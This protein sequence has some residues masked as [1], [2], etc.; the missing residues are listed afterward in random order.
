[1]SGERYDNAS[2][3]EA[4]RYAANLTALAELM[5]GKTRQARYAALAEVLPSPTAKAAAEHGGKWPE[6][7]DE[8][9]QKGRLAANEIWS[10]FDRDGLPTYML[11]RATSIAPVAAITGDVADMA[12]LAAY[13]ELSAGRAGSASRRAIFNYDPIGA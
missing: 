5:P 9:V 4:R 12:L 2:M 1:M 10:A 13:P 8:R 7:A 11:A 3:Q 6:I